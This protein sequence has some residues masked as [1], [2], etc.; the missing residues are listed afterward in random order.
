MNFE[1]H[2]NRVSV[3]IIADSLQQA[4]RQ[5]AQAKAALQTFAQ[6]EPIDDEELHLLLS[7]LTARLHVAQPPAC[8]AA[9]APEQAPPVIPSVPEPAPTEPAATTEQEPAA[10]VPAG[11]TLETEETA[12]PLPPLADLQADLTATGKEIFGGEWAQASPW[13]VQR[14]TAKFTPDSVRDR[15]S[16]L[17]AAEAAHLLAQLTDNAMAFRDKWAAHR[18]ANPPAANAK[19]RSPRRPTATPPAHPGHVVDATG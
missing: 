7:D 10:T 6:P 17:T 18:Q 16:K 8:E 12:D 14:Y 11:D 19:R 4:I 2:P 13:L 5:L 15:L 3:S 1:I 9:A